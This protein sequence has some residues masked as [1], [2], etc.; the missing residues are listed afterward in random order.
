MGAALSA[1]LSLRWFRERF[2]PPNVTFEQ[3]AQEAAGAP[4]GAEGLLFLPYLVGERTPHFDPQA[5][6][7]LVGLTLRHGRPHI[8]RAIMEGV[9]FSMRDALEIMRG[10][11][12]APQRV[13]AAGGGGS[14]PVWRQI[15][16]D[17]FKLPVATAQGE[18]RTAVGAALLAGVGARVYAD[19]AEAC[20]RTVRYGP[21]VEPSPAAARYA[22]L[23]PI[24]RRLYPRLK[25]EFALLT[26]M[27]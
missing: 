22:G 13:I 3:L 7:A 12:L 25:D 14:S 6:G 20:A 27:M 8:V 24:Y 2:C 19:V 10:L 1:G 11:G 17:V 16:A 18:E 26:D 4:P 9:A 21:S 5:R 23:Y 15:L